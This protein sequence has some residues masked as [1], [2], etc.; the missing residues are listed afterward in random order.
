MSYVNGTSLIRDTTN[1]EMAHTK[2]SM[3]S[4]K[5]FRIV[6]FCSHQ[7]YTINYIFIYMSRRSSNV[8]AM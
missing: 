6:A 1:N 7:K 2:S 8:D 4:C 3:L 5:T